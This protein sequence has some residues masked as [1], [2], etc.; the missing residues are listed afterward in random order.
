VLLLAGLSTGHKIGL[1]VVGAT[2]IVFALTASFVIPRKRPEF[3]GKNGLSVFVL[4]SFVLFFAMLT[5]VIVFGVESEAKGAEAKP[6]AKG[7]APAAAHSIPVTESEFK[8]VLPSLKTTA[9]K[10]TFAVKN[11]GKI[12][13]DLAV[14]GPGITGT[15][16]TPLISAGKSAN[17]TVT[18]TAGAYTLYCTVPGHRTLGMVATLTVS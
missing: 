3:P 7:G 18:L 14:T 8:I 2:F 10:V 5:A 6:P 15:T 12:Q 9:G 11:A 1:A 16:K 17:L 13:H 4:A